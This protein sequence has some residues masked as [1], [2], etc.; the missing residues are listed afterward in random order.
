M[1]RRRRIDCEACQAWALRYE[2]LGL[3]PYYIVVDGRVV[4]LMA[5]EEQVQENAVETIELLRVLGSASRS[6]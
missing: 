4:G 3:L 2:Q 6:C 5:I 1:L